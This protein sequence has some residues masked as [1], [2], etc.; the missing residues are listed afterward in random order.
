MSM[1]SL[2]R[3]RFRWRSMRTQ[4]TLWNI[5]TLAA[6]LGVLGAFI[7]FTVRATIMGAVDREL[8][9]S[10]RRFNR[11]PRP[12]GPG[13]GPDGGPDGGPQGAR[14][15]SQSIG[16]PPDMPDG[17]PPPDNFDGGPGPG[18]PM[19]GGPR[20]P[21]SGAYAPR[22][23]GPDGKVFAPQNNLKPWDSAAV[24]A[25]KGGPVFTTVTVAEARLRVLT[26]PLRQD[27]PAALVQVVYPLTDVDQALDGVNKAMFTLIPVALLC[28]GLG[29]ALLTGRALKPL[30]RLTHTAA[31]IGAE[32]LSE[33]LPVTG[34]DEFSDLSATFNAMLQRLQTSFDEQGLLVEELK[35]LI[36]QERRFTADA[37]HEL[38]TPLTV[39]KANT[40]LALSDKDLTDDYRQTMEDINRA[41]DTA[42]GLVRDLLLL[43]RSDAG[44]LGHES[45][46]LP[47][48]EVL[49][50]AVALFA[51]HGRSMIRMDA[52]D[53]ALCVLG[54][55]DELVRLFSNLLE[56]ALRY[57][58]ADGTVTVTAVGSGPDV[59]IAVTD[60][61]IGVAPEHLAH[62]GERFYRVDPSRARTGGGAGLGLSICK[63]I[64][65]AYGGRLRIQSK[66]GIGTT[67]SITLPNAGS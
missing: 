46:A 2:P 38:R 39:I 67:V 28:A 20:R 41:A 50:R 40:S 10:A 21:M 54:N 51:K 7:R 35:R 11:G 3:P 19:D 31:R 14:G 66:E 43:A 63:G 22:F 48:R 57:T 6:M 49:E 58:P 32:D 25:A 47:I 27:G 15:P 37:S 55:E 18:G 62:L 61:G 5:V 26:Q 9:A 59:H 42:S 60:T 65:E 12:G 8:Q 44:Q 16:P 4:L 17:G 53:P 34:E 29:G 33:R 64:V 1:L 52:P 24:A 30:R 36:E 23:I 56:N 13:S 45:I